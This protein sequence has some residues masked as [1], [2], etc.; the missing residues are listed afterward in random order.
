MVV[1]KTPRMVVLMIWC[2][3]SVVSMDL[4]SAGDMKKGWPFSDMMFY[5]CQ[6][7]RG[8]A[9]LEKFGFSCYFIH[10]NSVRHITLM[11]GII[12][13]FEQ[14]ESLAEK[15][16]HHQHMIIGHFGLAGGE[17][18]VFFDLSKKPLHIKTCTY[19]NKSGWRSRC[20]KWREPSEQEVTQY[21]LAWAQTWTP[22]DFPEEKE[23]P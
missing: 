21:D 7:T 5:E 6:Q 3:C 9:Q 18:I 16:Q 1:G 14:D 23:K 15:A 13:T 19:K 2:V 10:K 17:H 12:N 4:A 22:E 11:F 8:K 20:S